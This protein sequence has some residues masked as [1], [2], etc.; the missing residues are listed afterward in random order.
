MTEIKTDKKTLAG[1]VA[2]VTGASRGVG[3]AISIQLAQNGATVLLAA[4]N[5]Q[6]LQETAQLIAAEGGRAE[7]IVTD[8]RDETSIKRLVAAA[9]ERFGRLDILVNNAGVAYAGPIEDTA[10]EQWDR[11]HSVNAR[12]AFILCREALALLKKA[13]KAYII[14]IGSVV[15]VKGYPL[16][17]AYTASKHA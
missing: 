2:I 7:S 9:A 3:K 14:N 17:T 4:T 8:L 15:S 13:K 12:G 16:Q 6:K 11:C 5:P 10:T 1:K